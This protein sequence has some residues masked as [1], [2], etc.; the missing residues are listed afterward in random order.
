VQITKQGGFLPF[1]SADA[2]FVYYDKDSEVDGIWRVP[3]DGGEE[4]LILDQLKHEMYGN[5]AVV[6]DGI[7][8]IRFDD[9]TNEEGAILFYDFAAGRVKKIVKLGRHHIIYGGLAVSS[10]RRSFLYTVWEHPGGD[11]MVVENFR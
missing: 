2:R 9:T 1:E 11:I 10:D 5:W 6:D 8:F 7:Y 4:I 3:I